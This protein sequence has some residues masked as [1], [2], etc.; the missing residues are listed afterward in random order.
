M[1]DVAVAGDLKVGF[2]TQAADDAAGGDEGDR[3]VAGGA[4]RASATAART[5]SSSPR[6]RYPTELL[7]YWVREHEIMSLEEAHWRLSDYPA[8]A[9]GL[10]GR[11]FLA[12]GMPAD[13]IVYDPERLDSLPR[14]GCGTTRRVSG[15]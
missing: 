12:E 4:S 9:A 7:G 2:A 13:V 10:K 8:M 1:L 15:A 6:P 11:G 5:R 3:H 14:S